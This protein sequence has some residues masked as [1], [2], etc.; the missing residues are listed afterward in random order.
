MRSESAIPEAKK[1]GT[2]DRAAHLRTARSEV[3]VQ[4]L[5]QRDHRVLRHVVHTHAG[6]GDKAGDGGGIHDV[7][8]VALPQQDRGED[9]YAVDDAPEIHAE[10]PAPV[11]LGRLPHDAER[12][13]PGV[14]AHD[15]HYAERLERGAREPLDRLALRDV[16]RLRGDREPARA[17]L[18]GSPGER[19]FVDVG[20]HELQPLCAERAGERAPEPRRCSGDHCDAVG[21]GLHLRPEYSRASAGGRNP[22]TIPAGTIARARGGDIQ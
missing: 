18:V 12:R 4:R 19:G 17:E 22:L 7:A 2:H 21:E 16:G 20:E 1:A 5:A 11:L 13:D 6:R 10:R 15:V 14:V 8:L 9:A 3:V